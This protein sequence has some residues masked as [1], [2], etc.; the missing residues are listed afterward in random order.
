[1]KSVSFP[2]SFHNQPWC[3]QP[4]TPPGLTQ[5]GETA[6]LWALEPGQPLGGDTAPVTLLSGL[7]NGCASSDSTEGPGGACQQVS[8]SELGLLEAPYKC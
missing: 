2:P 8:G 6:W 5:A 1:M 4:L 7:R 3:G